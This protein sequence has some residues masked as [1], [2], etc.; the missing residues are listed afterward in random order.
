MIHQA[1][2][3]VSLFRVAVLGRSA[4]AYY[5][6]ILHSSEMFYPCYILPSEFLT[7]WPHVQ[8]MRPQTWLLVV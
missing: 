7:S 6:N 8:L 4:Y 1:F 5:P 3:R 2:S